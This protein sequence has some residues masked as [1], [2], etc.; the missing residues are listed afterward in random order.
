[1]YLNMKLERGGYSSGGMPKL[2][3]LNY[4]LL[5]FKLLYTLYETAKFVNIPQFMYA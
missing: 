5:L 4:C 2:Q 1:M 3:L